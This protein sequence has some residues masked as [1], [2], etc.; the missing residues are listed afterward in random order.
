M[1]LNVDK[2]KD[3]LVAAWRE[4]M[5]EKV[6]TNWA[7]FGYDGLSY[8]L[9][10]VSKGD[11]GLEELIDDLNSGKIMY[12]LSRVK[13]KEKNV[14][15]IVLINWQGEGAPL[16]R[17][18]MC[19]NHSAQVKNF[20]PGIHV[21]MNARTEEDVE[22]DA[23]IHFIA[24]ATAGDGMKHSMANDAETHGNIGPVG[25][26]YK[27]TNPM[28]D[29]NSSAKDEFWRK[30]EQ[31]E[32]RRKRDEQNKLRKFSQNEVK[33]LRRESE[34]YFNE[35]S[36]APVSGKTNGSS[37][38]PP[39]QTNSNNNGSTQHFTSAA[40]VKASTPRKNSAG[41]AGDLV[42]QRIKS[43]DFSG[44]PPS[45][46]TNFNGANNTNGKPTETLSVLKRRQMFEG[47][48]SNTNAAP[49]PKANP[50]REIKLA[51]EKAQ[52]EQVK[53]AKTIS[54]P[55]PESVIPNKFQPDPY[56]SITPPKPT[57]APD[58]VPVTPTP[59]EKQ[60]S[61]S[62]VPPP[63]AFANAVFTESVKSDNNINGYNNKA[64]DQDESD[65]VYSETITTNGNAEHPTQ[66]VGPAASL[67]PTSDLL[68][69]EASSTPTLEISSEM[70]VCA[71]ALYD[72]QAA[73]DSEITF[74]PGEIITNIEKI[75]E[76]WW[77]GLGPHGIYGLFPANYVELLN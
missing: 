20:F 49:A 38:T 19:A 51:Q 44:P 69:E 60:P 56:N 74:D 27:K 47:G 25:T 34:E 64:W 21:T 35:V 10:L 75:D 22:P 31:E 1:T 53:Q 72:Y 12:A 61:S 2:N 30:E 8:D 26:T 52:I 14:E 70:G 37:T 11:G 71:R 36:K 4:V 3:A 43:F 76:G 23:V 67:A 66:V 62:P 28:E 68:R 9:N 57:P 58:V 39:P 77:E 65:S 50:A 41:S 15:K 45:P 63:T 54:N 42:R 73:D 13:I 40:A 18:G 17:K 29:I 33:L 59:L 7:L 46:S 5:D 6:P 24:K 32:E 55:V 48:F 16:A